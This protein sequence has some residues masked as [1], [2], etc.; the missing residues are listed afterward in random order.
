MNIHSVGGWSK[1]PDHTAITKGPG[2]KGIWI[3]PAPHLIVG[4]VKNWATQANVE[5]AHIPAY[6]H[7]DEG[8]DIPA[9]TNARP[10]EKVLYALHG[11]GYVSCSAH[12]SDGTS[13]IPR[14]ILKHTGPSLTRALTVEYR[15][16]KGPGVTPSHP[17]PTA[18]VDAVAGY[19][20][21]VNELGF[22][23]EDIIVEGDSA[24]G[25]L[26]LALVRYLV[27]NQGKES[28]SIPR[29]PSALIVSS[30]WA[31]MGPDPTD[32]QSSMYTNVESDFIY[33]V[34]PGYH[35]PW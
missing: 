19:S 12:P 35:V 25:N 22:A 8:T 10:G 4:D 29:P 6:W 9:G 3:A 13:H 32:P 17:F 28:P 18:L 2:V 14:G 23:P 30:P 16:S 27:E 24:G 20:Y 34:G 15:L 21:L 31:D 1:S 33:M 26:A 11:G 5:S 7:D